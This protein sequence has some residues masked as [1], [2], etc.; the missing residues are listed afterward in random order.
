[1]PGDVYFGD[2]EK[3]LPDWRAEAS[4]SDL[5]D[6]VPLSDEERKGLVKMLG[7]DPA[8]LFEDRPAQEPPRV[9]PSPFL[10]R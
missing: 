10:P 2:A 5:D 7:F 1:M 3:P 4:P 9:P 6:D 8:E